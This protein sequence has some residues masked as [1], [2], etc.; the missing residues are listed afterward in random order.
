MLAAL[1]RG[2]ILLTAAVR[3]L[4]LLHAGRRRQEFFP[5]GVAAKVKRLSIAFGMESGC[6]VHCHSTDGVFGHSFRCFHCC[7]PFLAV[8]TLHTAH[9]RMVMSR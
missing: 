4:L 5:A 8:V 1:M 9:D 7:V 3:L 6:F 2:P